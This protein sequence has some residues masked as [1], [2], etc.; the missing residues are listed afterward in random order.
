[1]KKEPYLKFLQDTFRERSGNFLDELSVNRANLVEE[2]INH[3]LEEEIF[4]YLSKDQ[5]YSHETFSTKYRRRKIT[6]NKNIYQYGDKKKGL[7][8]HKKTLKKMIFWHEDQLFSAVV[9]ALNKILERHFTVDMFLKKR[10]KKK[11]LRN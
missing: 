7:K 5:T 11:L 10:W 2:T 8:T 1:M 6:T 3:N 9:N 4:S